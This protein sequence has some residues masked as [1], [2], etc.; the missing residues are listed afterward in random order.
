MGNVKIRCVWE[1]NGADSLIYS[2]DFVGAFTRGKSKEIAEAKVQQEIQSYLRWKNGGSAALSDIEVKIVQEK[3]SDLNIADADS[4]VLFE[5]EKD[6]L[7]MEEYTELKALA[8]RSA[9]DFLHLYE[10]IPDKDKSCLPERRTFYGLVPRT[11][12]EMYEHTKNVNAYYF[13]EIDV[14]A[15]NEGTIAECRRKGFEALEKQEKFLENPIIE[16]S[17]GELWTLRKVLR[18]FIWHDRIHARAMYRMAVRTFPGE[19]IEDPFSF[20]R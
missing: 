15:D 11:A 12:R 2:T 7:S 13:G 6:V 17:Y 14:D 4:D 8:L 5:T 19:N 20:G 16:G 9:A 1:H 10:S 3:T 18:R